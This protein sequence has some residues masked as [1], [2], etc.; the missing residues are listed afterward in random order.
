MELRSRYGEFWKL[1]ETKEGYK[2]VLPPY[3]R[4]GFGDSGCLCFVDPPGGPFI[5]V[6]DKLGGKT[7]ISM[8]DRDDYIL[9]K[10]EEA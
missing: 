10:M 3:S 5:E 1:E 2:F 6:G 4:V 9:L 7:I 8:E